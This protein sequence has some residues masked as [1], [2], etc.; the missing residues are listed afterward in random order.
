MTTIDKTQFGP[1]ALITGASSGIGRRASRCLWRH[2]FDGPDGGKMTTGPA[3][4][5]GDDEKPG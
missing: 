1:W 3:Y 4:T 5:R 2:S